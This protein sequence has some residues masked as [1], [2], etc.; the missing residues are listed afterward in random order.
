MTISEAAE[1]VIQAG[2]S[3]KKPK[4]G[5]AAPVYLLDMGEPVKI[6]D[7]ACQMIELS[8]LTVYDRQPA[9]VI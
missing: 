1:L 3:T 9:T 6:Y 8:G 2:A 7:L 4:T 5:Q